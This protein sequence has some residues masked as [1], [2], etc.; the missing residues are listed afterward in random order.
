MRLTVMHRVEDDQRLIDD[1]IR[2]MQ[3]QTL[4]AGTPKP[5]T[6]SHCTTGDGGVTPTRASDAE[7]HRKLVATRAP[8]VDLNQA[9]WD[10]HEAHWKE[11]ERRNEQQRVDDDA[12][13]LAEVNRQLAQKKAKQAFDAAEAT[14]DLALA[15]LTPAQRGRVMQRLLNEGKI[16][17]ADLAMGYALEEKY[18]NAPASDAPQADWRGGIKPRK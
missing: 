11:I 7:E 10:A 15:D 3:A 2:R 1:M 16:H 5:S 14:M 6:T 17:D 4:P 18:S 9:R 8:L 13:R 12:A